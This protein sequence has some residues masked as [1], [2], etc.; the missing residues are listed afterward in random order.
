MNR[1]AGAVGYVMD[2]R[3]LRR[4]ATLLVG[5]AE[6]ALMH[7]EAEREEAYEYSDL[8]NRLADQFDGKPG[9]STTLVDAFEAFDRAKR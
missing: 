2:A 5:H 9:T 8:L 1:E 4:A 6:G 7:K 3:A